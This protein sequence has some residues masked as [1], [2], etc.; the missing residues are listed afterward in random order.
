M[1]GNG[2]HLD[3][4]SMEDELDPAMPVVAG[5][6]I[7]E[8]IGKGGMGEVYVAR[9]LTLGRLV[10]IKFLIPESQPDPE[11]DLV[12]F[13]REAKL[14]ARVSHPNI[15]SIF[16]FGEADGRPFLVM[17]YVEG[18]DLR[19]R[20]AP[21]NPMSAEQVRSILMPVGEAL[22]YLHRH[23]IIHRD[24]KPENIL[25]H[26]GDNPRVSDFGIA[27]LR[28]GAGALTRTTQGLGTL[29]Y[30]APE[31]QYRLK[32]DDRADQYSMAAVAYE[33]LTGQLPLGIFK[34]PSDLNARLG[35]E[36]DMV[37]LRALQENPNDRYTTIRE[38]SV[39]LGKALAA[40]PARPAR[41]HWVQ[42]A[43]VGLLAVAILGAIAYQLFG[44][45]RPDPKPQPNAAEPR[46]D[47]PAP[48]LDP[49]AQKLMD[50]VEKLKA[51][52]AV[53]IWEAQGKPVGA[54]GKAV[55]KAN[56]ER[57]TKE[58][59]EEIENLAYKIWVERGSKL[60]PEGEVQKPENFRRAVDHLLEER[61]TPKKP[62]GP[63]PQ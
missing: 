45:A 4:G 6:E 35:S 16:D 12:R 27:V 46:V 25:L 60:G 58:V 33:M 62:P 30:V 40:P 2:G 17:E 11:R 23:Q 34:P 61:T 20:L 15:L 37:L 50:D 55:E 26:D 13:R 51:L 48:P 38:F 22:A 39:A 18:G 44:P 7:R 59:N 19:R 32:V 43:T 9:Q 63:M 49:V 52:R 21:G 8:R 29:G 10:A 53:L 57:A 54:A 42:F 56:W 41:P 1:S 3:F 5:Y 47:T 28:A 36:V 24:L 14:M 31:Q